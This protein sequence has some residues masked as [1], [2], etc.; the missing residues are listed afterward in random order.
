MPAPS[1]LP[2]PHRFTGQLAPVLSALRDPEQVADVLDSNPAGVVL[3]EATPELTVVY[4]NEAFQ[5]LV[6][7][8]GRPAVGRPLSDLFAWADRASVRAA[9]REVLRTGRPLP[10]RSSRHHG[11]RPG[12]A[13]DDVRHISHF[14]L[15]DAAGDITHV[16]SFTM[17]I[18]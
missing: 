5:R 11:G 6:P 13:G 2:E 18:S 3:V 15:H 12:G 7:L 8:G 9:Y 16:L 17:D 10:W 14:P 4:C 1:R